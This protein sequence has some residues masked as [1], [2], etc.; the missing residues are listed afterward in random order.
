[1]A[2]IE[3]FGITFIEAMA[4][5]LPIISFNTK[6]AN[7]IITNNYNGYIIDFNDIDNFVKKIKD[8]YAN[9]QMLNFVE[10]NAFKTAE[11]YDLELVTKKLIN[12]YKK[13]SI[14]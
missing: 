13:V 1:M 9:K 7:E 14:S 4:S 6:G 5:G 11:K 10:V 12:I 3:S 8:I 2:R